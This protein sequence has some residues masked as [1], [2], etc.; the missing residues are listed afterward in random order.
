M[1][2]K[3]VIASGKGGVGKTSCCVAIGKELARRDHSV[4]LVD[5]DIGLRSLDVLLGVSERIVYDWGDI[6][7]G[8][9][10]K[11][12]ALVNAGGIDLLTCPLHFDETYT[13]ESVKEMI[14]LFDG[15][16]DYILIDAPAGIDTGF[17]L[18]SSAADRA[19]IVSTADRV[20]V[21]SASRAGEKLEQAGMRDIR[22]IINRFR[23]KSVASRKML[24]IDKVIDETMLQLIGVVPEDENIT[25]GKV[26]ERK[27]QPSYDAFVRIA[28]RIKKEQIPLALKF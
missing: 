15:D 3:I 23:R 2:E 26:M 4:L 7:K 25:F 9:C 18:A 1:A 6:I 24:N 12:T 17:E 5:G 10:M 8:N 11:D 16:Y 13:P 28:G 14:M 20:C 21:R 27:N 22:L 19:L